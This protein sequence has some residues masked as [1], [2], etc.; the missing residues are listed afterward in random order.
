ML[1]IDPAKRQ[2]GRG[3]IAETRV[4]LTFFRRSPVMSDSLLAPSNLAERQIALR[5]P[6]EEIRDAEDRMRAV[7]YKSG[8]LSASLR[9]RPK[10]R[11]AAK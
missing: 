1:Q 6:A 7:Y 8:S 11:V 10:Y 4:A 2:R 9:K 5:R 3:A